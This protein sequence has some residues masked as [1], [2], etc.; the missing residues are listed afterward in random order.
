MSSKPRRAPLA[1]LIM[2]L[3][4]LC[5]SSC[6]SSDKGVSGGI[7]LDATLDEI[8]RTLELDGTQAAQARPPLEI[9]LMDRNLLFQSIREEGPRGMAR[10]RSEMTSYEQAVLS[11]L[12]GIL[13]PEQMTVFDEILA[14]Q[15]ER[16]RDDLQE[17]TDFERSPSSMDDFGSPGVGR[18]R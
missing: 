15:R 2:I 13:S 7:D 4:G 1:L 16:M 9:F 6:S 5:L 8:C 10:T 11:E 12:S 3:L 14:Q 18:G 17:K